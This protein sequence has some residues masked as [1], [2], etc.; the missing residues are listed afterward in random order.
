MFTK[1]KRPKSDVGDTETGMAEV[2]VLTLPV[3]GNGFH[4]S[5]PVLSLQHRKTECYARRTVS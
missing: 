3:L 1:R 5:W 4:V 2:I